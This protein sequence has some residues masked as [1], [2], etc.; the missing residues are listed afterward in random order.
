MHLLLDNYATVVGIIASL[1]T[2]GA[3]AIAVVRWTTGA[4]PRLTGKVS[5]FRLVLGVALLFLIAVSVLYVLWPLDLSPS[6]QHLV[7][8]ADVADVS[9]ENSRLTGFRIEMDAR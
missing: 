1:I 9:V 6:L 8:A 7:D 4:A 5:A 2:I 3:F